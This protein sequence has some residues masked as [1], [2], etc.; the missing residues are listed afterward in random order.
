MHAMVMF[1]LLPI[2]KKYLPQRKRFLAWFSFLVAFTRIYFGFHFL[3]D[4]VFGIFSGYF[5]GN[6]M[7]YL[8]ERGVLWKKV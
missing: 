6:Y 5:I 3:S 1:S 4:I 8:H 7:V 2:T